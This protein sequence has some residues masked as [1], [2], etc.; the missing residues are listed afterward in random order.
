MR[1]AL[2]KGQSGSPQA[3]FWALGEKELFLNL[4]S[5]SAGLTQ[6]VATQ[7]LKE[8]GPNEIRE[9]GGRELFEIL[10]SQF[11]NPL[12]LVL[13]AAA[14]ISFFLGDRVESGVIVF[15]VVVNAIL[16]LVQEYRAN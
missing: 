8:N 5:S 15:I 16:G 2:E 1:H 7:M 11:K 4:K 3:R 12:V 9:T 6:S 14:I 10:F 13:I